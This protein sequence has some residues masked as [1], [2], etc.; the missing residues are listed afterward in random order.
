MALKLTAEHQ[1]ILDIFSGTTQYII[2][3]YQRSYSWEEE[4]CLE[5]LEDLKEAYKNNKKQKENK[6]EGYFLGNIVTAKSTESGDLEEVIDGQQRLTTLTLLIYVL[7]FFDKDNKH[8]LDAITI[9]AGSRRELPKPR[10][11]TNMFIEKDARSLNEALKLNFDNID[12]CKIGKRDSQ[13]KKNICYFYQEIQKISEDKDIDI[14]D[15]IDFLLFDVSILP[16]KTEDT[17]PD[18]AREKAL[19]IFETINNRG[20]SLADSDIFKAKLYALALSESKAD[21]F[22]KEWKELEE[23]SKELDKP[24]GG[25]YSINDI[26]RFYTQIIRGQEGILTSERGLREFFTQKTYSPFKTKTSEDVMSDLFKIVSIVRFFREVI[27]NPNKYEELTKWFQ[28]LEQY[29]NQY[30][31]NALVVYLYV[32]GIDMNSEQLELFARN[33]VRYSFYHGVTTKVK[34]PLFSFIAK[35]VKEKET[36]FRL[37]FIEKNQKDL[38]YFGQLKKGFTLLAFYLNNEQKAIYP[39]YFNKI[40]NSRDVKTLNP[41]WSGIELTYTDYSDTLGNMIIIDKNISRDVKLLKKEE[42]LKDSSI[43]EI[44]ELANKLNHWRY[45]DYQNREISLKNRLIKFFKKTDDN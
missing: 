17:T 20:L 7:L 36:T 43:V 19:K 24:Q 35:V 22:I 5:L 37:P 3:A 33:L 28:L 40:I 27:E 4:Q 26:F 9:P 42:Y 38:L 23:Q 1:R 29:S 18:N 2:P 13:Y 41:T 45:E 25:K 12:V 34:F 32:H 15:F 30:P 10:L 44:K 16:I 21:N 14:F 11:K 39:N 6:K 31:L 8:L